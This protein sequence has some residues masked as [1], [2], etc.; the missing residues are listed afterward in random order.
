VIGVPTTSVD[1]SREENV[2]KKDPLGDVE[3]LFLGR[4][5]VDVLF[6]QES[7]YPNGQ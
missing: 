3:M 5:D 1:Y 7:G 4:H 6:S 2:S